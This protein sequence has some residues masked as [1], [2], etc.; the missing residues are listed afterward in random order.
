MRQALHASAWVALRCAA[1]YSLTALLRA[2][3]FAEASPAPTVAAGVLAS[4]ATMR[5]SLG[6]FA[7]A[8]LHAAIAA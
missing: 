2:A 4:L 5:V 7:G 6:F 8:A 1:R 3:I